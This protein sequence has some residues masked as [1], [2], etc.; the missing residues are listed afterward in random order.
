[1]NV[2]RGVVAP[3]FHRVDG[4]R[5]RPGREPLRVSVPERVDRVC[6]SVAP[7]FT[8]AVRKV[9]VRAAARYLEDE[10]ELA[11]ERRALLSSLPGIGIGR[12]RPTAHLPER[13][14]D[15]DLQNGSAFAIEVRTHVRLVPDESVGVKLRRQVHAFFAR[16]CLRPVV[17][18]PR[19]TPVQRGAERV[20]A[21][22]RVGRSVASRLHDVYLP[23]RR[24]CS[25]LAL[26]REQPEGRPQ[27]VAARQHGANLHLPV[28]EGERIDG[29]EG[30]GFDRIEVVSA[31]SRRPQAAVV[32]IRGAVRPGSGSPYIHC[33]PSLQV[34]L[35]DI[36]GQERRLNIENAVP[37]VAVG[38]VVIVI[39][40]LPVP[41]ATQRD[42]VL[43]HTHIERV[44]L[45]I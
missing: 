11:I 31:G 25:V 6:V 5:L 12:R 26:L 3:H 30:G 20:V 22:R 17:H 7:R 45:I 44:E 24:P 2:S 29:A 8:V 43:P 41:S 38:A 40:K 32:S 16:V 23:A 28:F 35:A 19:R 27:P 13:L 1:M 39:L 4:H 42:L 15:G 18:I 37:H 9:A 21:T 36:V 10:E 33:V 14:V 34:R